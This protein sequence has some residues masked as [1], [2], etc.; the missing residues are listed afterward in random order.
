MK[1]QQTKTKPELPSA[2]EEFR[3]NIVELTRE[4][5]GEEK[6]VTFAAG[7]LTGY[8]LMKSR[9]RK[10]VGGDIEESVAEA[11][12]HTMATMRLADVVS[13]WPTED[14]ETLGSYLEDKDLEKYLQLQVV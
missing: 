7:V 12:R 4:V 10:F 2:L 3:E 6:A 9:A 8:E 11:N 13:S 5:L 1:T 14:I